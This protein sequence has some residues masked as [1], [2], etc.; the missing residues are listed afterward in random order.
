[1]KK[2]LIPIGL[3]IASLMVYQTQAKQQTS[4]QTSKEKV[5]IFAGG[6]FW[7]VEAGFEKLT[8]VRDAVSGYIG[9]QV[10]NPSYHQVGSGG[11]GHTEA[12]KVYYNPELISYEALVYSFWRQINPTD[13]KGQFVD[14][15]DQYR[16]EIFYLNNEQKQIAQQSKQQLNISGVYKK[17]VIVPITAASE[18]YNAE[19]YHQ[20]YYKKNPLRYK[21][22]RYGS[23]RDKYLTSIWGDDLKKP[24]SS[25][26]Q[27]TKKRMSYS[28]PTDTEL[29]KTLT[30]L[31]YRVTQKEGTEPPFENIYWD[32]HKEG[33]YVDVTTG[34]PLFSSIDKF[35][36]GTGWPSFTKPLMSTHIVEKKDISFF[37]TRTEVRSETGDAHLGHVFNDGPKP[38]GKRYCINSASLKFIPKADLAKA[39]YSQLIDL[40]K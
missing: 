37:G 35:N 5:A 30:D 9:G 4:S 25:T 28:K 36:S 10:K 8:G 24:F 32:N 16:P 33:I 2:I 34:E 6:C 39:G 7:C 3:A 27:Q 19:K 11:T 29:K 12:V 40:F 23:G 31:Q 15:G 38:T 20:D 18:F 26:Q 22:Y 14:R 13:I 17:P 21:Y 1:M